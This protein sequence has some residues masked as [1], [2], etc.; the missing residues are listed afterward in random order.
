MCMLQFTKS[1]QFSAWAL[2]YTCFSANYE[3]RSR[4]CSQVLHLPQV[5][6]RSSAFCLKISHK[7]VFIPAWVVGYLTLPSTLFLLQR[8]FCEH[9]TCP[10][11]N[12]CDEVSIY[13]L[14][15][16]SWRVMHDMLALKTFINAV[17]PLPYCSCC[18]DAV[19]RWH[20]NVMSTHW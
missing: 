4:C 2:L 18:F 3:S 10:Q 11:L 9:D 20:S 7:E 6:S 15:H 14:E 5:M 13:L 12:Y 17:I 16:E 1:S 8:S 19:E